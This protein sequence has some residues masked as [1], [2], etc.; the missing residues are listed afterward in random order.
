M[1]QVVQHF[2]LLAR[3]RP[4]CLPLPARIRNLTGLAEQAEATRDQG[5]ASAVLNQAALLASDTGA[6]EYAQRLCRDQAHIF[7]ASGPLDGPTAIRA[8]E[9]IINLGRLHTRAGAPD[10]ARSNLAHLAEAIRTRTEATIHGVTISSRLVVDDLGRQ[11]VLAWLWRVT[12]A[13]GTRTLTTQ[14][15]WQEALEHV[16]AHRGIGNRMLDGRQVAVAAHLMLQDQQAATALVA[17]TQA[18]EPWEND[19][20]AL[21]AATCRQATVGHLSEP[22]VQ[23]LVHLGSREHEP[24]R[25]VFATR[26]ALAAHAQLRAHP[27]TAVAAQHLQ[28][29]IRRR[30][31]AAADGYAAWDAL[32]HLPVTGPETSALR[33][34]VD[35]CALG[36][37]LPTEHR[38]VLDTATAI[39]ADTIR[40]S[41]R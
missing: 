27:V 1:R 38:V 39:A 3:H 24:G 14:G 6:A 36:R 25:T 23:H 34:L 31:L 16:R 29:L 19:V 10:E 40:A 5:T 37:G 15:R 13:D 12:L 7:L 28:A 17:A 21:L 8:L 30:V 4:A 11:E 33:E 18:G 32:A 41:L 20:T 22:T 2:P 35:L 26:L 9:P